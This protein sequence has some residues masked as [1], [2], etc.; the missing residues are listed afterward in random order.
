MIVTPANMIANPANLTVAASKAV[1][2]LAKESD[3][4]GELTKLQ[5]IKVEEVRE[6]IAIVK[7][8]IEEGILKRFDETAEP[9]TH[10]GHNIIVT[11]VYGSLVAM[12]LIGLLIMAL[13]A[14]FLYKGMKGKLDVQGPEQRNTEPRNILS[15]QNPLKQTT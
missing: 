3:G 1:V 2:G 12:V 9:E 15:F 8:A 4:A 10:T 7:K 14:T 13:F 5:A 11:G 6:A